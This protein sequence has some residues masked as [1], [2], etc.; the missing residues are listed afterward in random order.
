L[1]VAG[2]TAWWRPL[3]DPQLDQLMAM[4]L[5]ANN[6]LSKATLA[7]RRAR[8][9]AAQAES[10]QLPSVSAKVG[11]SATRTL[12]QDGTSV[13]HTSSLLASWE[14]D[15]WGRVSA[16]RDA[17][18]FEAQATEAE[19]QAVALSLT[20]SVANAW[21]QVA[22]LN[23]RVSTS[24][25]SLAYARQTLKLVDAQ[26]RAG[27]NSGLE[28]AQ[29]QQTVAA[30]E[31]AHT[32][33]LRQLGEARNTLGLL[34][35]GPPGAGSATRQVPE[36]TRLSEATLPEVPAGLPA[37]LLTRRP[38]LRAAELRLRRTLA[39]GDATRTAYYPTLSLTG[40]LYGA[41]SSLSNVLAHPQAILGAGLSLPFIQWRD[42]QR[43]ANIAQVDYESAVVGFRQS[44]YQA[45]ADV[46]NA[47]NA[48][49]HY[50]TQG[51][52][53]QAALEAAQRA[54]R[55]AEARYRAGSVALKTW[56]DAQET[57]RQTE[58]NLAA[59]RL[60]RLNAWVSLV[61]SLGG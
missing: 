49:Q 28:L 1:P 52:R 21:W 41:S 23:Q 33:W 5:A 42:M 51:E 45:L 2:L 26:H 7:A 44:W 34:V 58:I 31:A 60:N 27:A 29:A 43:A 24:D 40:Q 57:R 12:G 56:L 54:E 32:Q 22:Y 61:Q 11:S 10:D 38:D 13:G 20:A 35:D 36:A 55:L 3:Q 37:E 14:L 19:R 18:A 15:L 6:S 17:A 48:R 50:D 30:Q 16:L 46:D 53:L 4:A 47:L 25:Q 39:N 8:L 59:N 9:V